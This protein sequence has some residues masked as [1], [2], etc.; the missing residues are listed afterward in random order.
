MDYR[1]ENGC[2]MQRMYFLMGSS[3]R[4]VA[5]EES[6]LISKP[7][8]TLLVPGACLAF[9]VSLHI[10]T[11]LQH[12]AIQAQALLSRNEAR[13]Y[14]I[15]YL[16]FPEF[17]PDELMVAAL[18]TDPEQLH[19]CADPLPRAR[20]RVSSCD[21]DAV[22]RALVGLRKK[23][24]GCGLDVGRLVS[25]GYLLRADPRRS[26]LTLPVADPVRIE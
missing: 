1:E 6:L 20:L 22:G 26:A 7:A 3:T 21:F 11:L 23:L 16:S 25:T 4:P 14:Q 24:R 15:L 13:L 2:P 10:L 18:W 12:E 5:S 17:V 8:P 9:N 19:S